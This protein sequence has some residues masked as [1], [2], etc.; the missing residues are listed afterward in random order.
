MI[1]DINAKEG[2]NVDRM[3]QNELGRSNASLLTKKSQNKQQS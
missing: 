3:G 2:Y 1:V